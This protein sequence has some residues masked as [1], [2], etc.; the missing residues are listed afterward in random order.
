MS[1]EYEYKNWFGAEHIQDIVEEE[2]GRTMS[3]CENT[4]DLRKGEWEETP[5]IL[6]NAIGFLSDYYDNDSE[7]DDE[8]ID[9]RRP[10][11]KQTIQKLSRMFQNEYL[12]QLFREKEKFSGSETIN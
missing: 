3:E 2:T 8:T 5:I 11:M 4:I 10:M 12:Q 7:D 9:D 1:K 6:M